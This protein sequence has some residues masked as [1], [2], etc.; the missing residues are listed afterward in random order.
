MR[1][2]R[3]VLLVVARD[4][5]RSFDPPLA[6]LQIP[7]PV[8]ASTLNARMLTHKYMFN[9]IFRCSKR[10]L[11]IVGKVVGIR[12][13]KEELEFMEKVA[14]EMNTTVGKCVKNAMEIVF[15]NDG[16]EMD[17]KIEAA[18][19]H[20]N[21][22]T[23]MTALMQLFILANGTFKPDFIQ[24]LAEVNDVEITNMSQD[25]DSYISPK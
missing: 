7:A 11:N 4:R 6:Y 10:V 25:H 17:E 12:L 14:T 20:M 15:F 13:N 18:K 5:A 24:W 2:F 19:E 8:C 22:N 16:T 21:W 9:I 1:R 23:A 3:C